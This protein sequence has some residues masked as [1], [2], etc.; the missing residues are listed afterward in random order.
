MPGGHNPLDKLYAPLSAGLHGE[1]D[2]DCLAI[3]SD[4][5]FAFEYLF[6]NFAESNAAARRYVVWSALV[7]N[8]PIILW[9][10]RVYNVP[11]DGILGKIS[12][13]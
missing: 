13:A 7:S 3:F 12:R 10:F 1:S 2:D 4:A 8:R 9:F 11:R 5:R 6:K